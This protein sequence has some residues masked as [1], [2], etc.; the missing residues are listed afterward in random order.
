M[1]KQG[2]IMEK[3]GEIQTARGRQ[4]KRLIVNETVR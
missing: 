3:Q 2:Q 4:S 1:E